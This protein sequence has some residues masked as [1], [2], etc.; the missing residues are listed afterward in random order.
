[1][2]TNRATRLALRLATAL[3][4]AFIYIPIG[5]I[6]V[7]SLNEAVTPAWP[8]TGF[9]LRWWGVAFENT[10]LRQAFLTS[11]TVALGAMAIALVLGTLA[12]IAVAR[13]RF[14]GRE[15]I[16]F[17]VVFPIALPGIVTG[18]ALSRT[19]AL[20]G[21]ELGWLSIVVGHATFCV[22]TVYNNVIARLRRSSRS[23]EEDSM[24]LGADTWQT[25][26]R[27]TLPTIATALLAGGLLAFALA[28]GILMAPLRPA[29]F[30]AKQVA[31]L[32]QLSG[33]RLIFGVGRSGFAHTYA[34]YGVD[35]GES[36][37]RFAEVLTILKRAF[38]EEQFSHNGRYYRYDNVRLAPRPLQ[39]PWRSTPNFTSHMSAPKFP[40]RAVPAPI[41]A[42]AGFTSA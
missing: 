20:T 9:T 13:H 26:R 22:V 39:M 38:T 11:V 28:T 37:E 17:F 40:T 8:P 27:V 12:A 2:G 41:T 14:F 4:L 1:M 19:F 18:M 24:D 3:T 34:T 15:A 5:L 31:T 25:F 21:F 7:Y 35:Y 10:G 36:R 32:D 23:I 29:A 16:S 33:G 30:L 6:V 42:P